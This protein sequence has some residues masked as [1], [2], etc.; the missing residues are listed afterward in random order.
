MPAQ[1]DHR[2]PL[3]WCGGVP[4]SR[5]GV[6]PRLGGGARTGG[7]SSGVV[8]TSRPSTAARRSGAAVDQRRR[9]RPPGG[10]QGLRHG[11][12]HAPGGATAGGAPCSAG[13]AGMSRRSGALTRS[14]VGGV[15]PPMRGSSG[16]RSGRSHDARGRPLHF[17]CARPPRG[18]RWYT[19]CGVHAIAFASP[20]EPRAALAPEKSTWK[21]CSRSFSCLF[22]RASRAS[23]S[24]V[25][26]RCRFCRKARCR[27]VASCE[28]PTVAGQRAW[29]S[30]GTSGGMSGLPSSRIGTGGAD[31]RAIS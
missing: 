9:V 8:G 20:R 28:L 6:I 2:L 4:P 21:F 16:S 23:R 17:A 26:R 5:S 27:C 30:V 3:R 22:S 1:R 14:V 10:E 7:G 18:G 25:F 12:Q 13:G 24:S 11:P 29:A 31:V 15:A 19:W